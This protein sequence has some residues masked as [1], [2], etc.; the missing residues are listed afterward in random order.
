MGDR[1][2][3]PGRLRD[4]GL[5]GD[6]SPRERFGAQAR[7]LLVGHGGDDHAAGAATWALKPPLGGDDHRRQSALHVLRAAAVEMPVAQHRRKWRRHAVHADGVGV[8]AQHAR[9]PRRGAIGHGDD[10][11][12]ARRDLLHF[13]VE[14][15]PPQIRREPLRDRPFTRGARAP[16]KG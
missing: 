12:P 13:D 10:V 1:H 6:P 5:V 14:A 16:A 9:R 3:H 2:C 15:G 11:G 7:V 4:H 8:T